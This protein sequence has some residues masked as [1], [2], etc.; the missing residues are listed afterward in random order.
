MPTFPNRKWENKSM[1]LPGSMVFRTSSV[2]FLV[3]CQILVILPQSFTVYIP[4]LHCLVE[5]SIAA[6]LD[7]CSSLPAGL[8]TFLFLI[9]HLTTQLNFL[10]VSWWFHFPHQILFP[11]YSLA[12]GKQKAHLFL[13]FK[14]LCNSSL[15]PFPLYVPV[16]ALLFPALCGSMF[17]PFCFLVCL[18]LS[19]T[20]FQ[21]LGPKPALPGCFCFWCSSQKSSHHPLTTTLLL[22]SV[23]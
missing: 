2:S 16:H 9:R 18:P 4:P 23:S 6:S 17:C 1:S 20:D 5:A 10:N 15:S 11:G 7:Y 14:D 12:K 21:S 13:V 3:C 22:H 19:P 8:I